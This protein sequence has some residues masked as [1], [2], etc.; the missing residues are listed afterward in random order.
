MT[1]PTVPLKQ[2][3]PIQPRTMYV[4]YY[5][6][7]NEPKVR[8][9]MAVC[10]EIIDKMNPERIYFL[11]ASSGG[12]IDSG[13]ALYN[14]LR[15][16]PVKIAFH[17]IGAVDS[18]ANVIFLA[19]EERYATS[20][21]TFLMHGVTWNLNSAFDREALGQINSLA[22]Q[23]ENKIAKIVSERTSLSETDIR[24]HF[25]Q[26]DAKDAKFALDKGII[27]KII[28]PTIPPNEKLIS[29]NFP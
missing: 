15:A 27:H 20:H 8:N 6:I 9:F 14:Y 16:L 26:G 7:I 4:N 19:G 2:L 1:T 25:A 5:D 3:P 12:H 10:A 24:S 23:A 21:A 18:I 17:N 22:I 13:I 11:F 29:L 28:N